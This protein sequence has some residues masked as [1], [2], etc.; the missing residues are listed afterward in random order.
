M[1]VSCP[2]SD[3]FGRFPGLSQNLSNPVRSRSEVGPKSGPKYGV[4]PKSGPKYGVGPKSEVGPK[5]G[6]KYGVGPKSELGPKLVRSL[7]SVR[8]RTVFSKFWPQS[9]L[10]A[11]LMHFGQGSIPLYERSTSLIQAQ[12]G[13]N[14]LVKG[15]T[16][17][18]R[19]FCFRLS[20]IRFWPQLAILA[21]FIVS[22]KG[23]FPYMR[24][25]PLLYRPSPGQII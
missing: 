24:G 16:S 12:P 22:A 7:K 20:D 18:Y 23:P 15:A 9:S 17:G 6:P 2:K 14:R 25:V 19:M 8:N 5:S 13:A 10:L 3:C 1:V 11:V 21:V 4:G